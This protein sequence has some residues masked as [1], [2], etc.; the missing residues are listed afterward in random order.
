MSAFPNPIPAMKSWLPAGLLGAVLLLAGVVFSDASRAGP[1]EPLPKPTGDVIL[2]ITGAI[3]RGNAHD[4]AGQ[5]VA[6]FDRA[7]LEQLGLHRVETNSPW[8]SSKV[9]FEGAL[10]R[11]ILAAVGATGSSLHAVAYNDY[12]TDIPVGDA[13]RYDVIL[14]MKANGDRLTLR[15]KGPLFVVYPYDSDPALRR[16]LIYYRSIWQLRQIDVR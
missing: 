1:S 9:R 12:S 16:D 14:A 2:T 8:Y 10:L 13:E 3:G 7:M 4:A 11:D 5:R 15:N 6:Q